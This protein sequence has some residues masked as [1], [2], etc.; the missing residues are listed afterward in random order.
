MQTHYQSPYVVGEF[1]KDVIEQPVIANVIMDHLREQKEWVAILNMKSV[2]KN[3]FTDI[4]IDMC[5]FEKVNNANKKTYNKLHLLAVINHKVMKI[6][7]QTR[8]FCFRSFNGSRT[9]FCTEKIELTNNLFDYMIMYLE[10]LYSLGPGVNEII[11]SALEDYIMFEPLYYTQAIEY[12]NRMYPDSYNEDGLHNEYDEAVEYDE[13]SF[14][15]NIFD[16]FNV[17]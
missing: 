8:Y 13:L 12:L 11:Q 9:C 6:N 15:K 10:T 7:T 4:P 2:F 17:G 5:V 14:I 1:I 3:R 16:L